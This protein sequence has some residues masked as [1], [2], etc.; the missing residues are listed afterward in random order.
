[1]AEQ[2]LHNVNNAPF[3]LILIVL[4]SFLLVFLSL[5]FFL[6]IVN[7][8][9]N[10]SQLI[11]ENTSQKIF[12]SITI[13]S[14]TFSDTNE[15]V[16]VKVS[17]TSSE[18]ASPLN[19]P[20]TITQT[21]GKHLNEP[22]NNFKSFCESLK[23]QYLQNSI[24]IQ[25]ILKLLS[26]YLMFCGDGGTFSHIVNFCLQITTSTTIFPVL[27]DNSTQT[28]V[29]ELEQINILLE[30]R[31]LVENQSVN[32]SNLISASIQTEQTVPINVIP[33][34]SPVSL[35]QNYIYAA[36]SLLIPSVTVM[37]HNID[38]NIE[39]E[40]MRLLKEMP[41][42]FGMFNEPSIIARL[43]DFAYYSRDL[44][45]KICEKR[46]TRNEYKLETVKW[47]NDLMSIS[48]IFCEDIKKL[49]FPLMIEKF[50][51][52]ASLSVMVL[53]DDASKGLFREITELHLLRKKEKS[54]TMTLESKY[55]IF[56]K[57]YLRQCSLIF[58][59][60]FLQ[61][62]QIELLKRIQQRIFLE[63]HTLFISSTL[64]INVL[65]EK[66]NIGIQNI[67]QTE[68]KVVFEQN[69][70]KLDIIFNTGYSDYFKYSESD[71]NEYLEEIKEI[72]QK[73]QLEIIPMFIGQFSNL[74]FESLTFAVGTS[75]SQQIKPTE[76]TYTP[77]KPLSLNE[78]MQK[79]RGKKNN[80]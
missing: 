70:Q 13:T 39:I 69:H 35:N 19:A 20:D 75:S 33:I 66:L 23:Q 6:Y 41:S 15:H 55:N 14:N 67:I 80:S 74:F 2:K 57:T 48:S 42:I 37:L 72:F 9:F 1:M 51:S 36:F 65:L 78:L 10:N 16:L 3:K 32:N 34:E 64:P 56:V 73:R 58:I 38:N 77:P 27:V 63:L 5:I 21:I 53:M 30:H 11:I 71:K 68:F 25:Q 47:E 43:Q 26:I 49:L 40:N 31:P 79:L 44:I 46:Q 76:Y 62:N 17:K 12:Q 29:V 7:F 60:E 18:I 22:S 8:I 24:T 61:N 45:A 50:T 59:N 4:L 52:G 28:N 54:D